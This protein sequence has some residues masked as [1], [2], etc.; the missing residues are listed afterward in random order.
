MASFA[1]PAGAAAPDLFSSSGPLSV[2]RPV[3]AAVDREPRA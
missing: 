1:V 3:L 2:D